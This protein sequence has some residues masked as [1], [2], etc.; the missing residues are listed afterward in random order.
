M[1]QLNNLF[2]AREELL[3]EFVLASGAYKAEL[4][5]K[6]IDLDEQIEDLSN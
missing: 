1:R 5:T 4:L 2:E 6:I 3:R